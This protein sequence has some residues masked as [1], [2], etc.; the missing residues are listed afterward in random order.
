MAPLRR[1]AGS[2]ATTLSTAAFV[3]ACLQLSA[4]HHSGVLASGEYWVRR[5]RQP[6]WAPLF[7][8]VEGLPLLEMPCVVLGYFVTF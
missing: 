3:L 8:V 1:F 5:M 6:P 7:G 2:D 4:A